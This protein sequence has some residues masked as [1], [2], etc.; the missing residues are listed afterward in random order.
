MIDNILIAA[1]EGQ[2]KEFI[3][4]V[5]TIVERIRRVNLLTSPDRDTVEKSTD[6]E[7]LLMSM[8]PNTFLGEEYVWN[9]K[10]RLIRNSIKTVAKLGLSL[11]ATSYTCRSFVSSVSLILYAMHTTRLNPAGA[12]Q[13]LRAYR[14]VYRTVEEG[15]DWDDPILYLDP[16]VVAK[17]QELGRELCRNEFW[18]IAD[19]VNPTYNESDYDYVAVTDASL[20][21]WG[22][23]VHDRASDTTT[24]YQQRWEKRNTFDSTPY[25]PHEARRK[26]FF[27]AQHSAHAEPRA[28]ELLIKQI[29]RHGL[30]DNQKIAVITDHEAIAK[31]Q[32]R[33][34][35]FGGIGRGY[36]LNKLFEF[37]YDL[38]FTRGVEVYFFWLKGT[39]NPADG[40][41]RTFGVT[42]DPSMSS[43]SLPT[44][45]KFHY[46]H[47]PSHRSARDSRSSP[48]TA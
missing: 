9:G 37:V 22:A 34:N 19:I 17:L 42:V 48:H 15:L 39:S 29:V 43:R 4:A 36:A 47:P 14:G 41:S 30:K 25:T 6:E 26:G 5:R 3:D 40:I 1:G 32:R 23:Y 18:Q 21:G 13:L 8:E 27:D 31:A 11:E 44:T 16:S 12:F 7:L 46:C 2:E 20:G 10:E 24:G 35:G 33:C 38:W 45:H 28:V